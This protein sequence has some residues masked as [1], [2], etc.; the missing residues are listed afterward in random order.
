MKLSYI[1][2]P[3]T[4]GLDKAFILGECGWVVDPENIELL[5]NSMKIIINLEKKGL[6]EFRVNGRRLTLDDFSKESILLKLINI[7]SEY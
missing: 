3:I 1:E 7:I 5:S 6:K 4:C 2:Q